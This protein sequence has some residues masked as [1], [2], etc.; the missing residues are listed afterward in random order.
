MHLKSEDLIRIEI[1]FDSGSIPP[2]F[3]HTFR[4]KISFEKNFLN[5]Q[6]DL[7]Y[8]HREELTDEEILDEGFPLDGNY[9]YVGELHNAWEKPLKSLYLTSKWSNKKLD[10]DEGGVRVLAKDLHGKITRTVPLNQEEWQYLAQEIIQAIYET[11]KKEAPLIIN[12]LKIDNDKTLEISL[13]MKFSIR[14]ALATIDGQEKEL[15]WEKTKELL[16]Y[17]FLP[18][19]DYDKAREGKPSKRGIYIDCGDGFW[20]EFGKGIYN[21]DSSYDA[22][23]KIREGFLKL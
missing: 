21:I 4:L 3:S 22:V 5:T 18:D 19:Y 6:L 9:N 11:S 17:V 8:T 23:S 1:D 14:K 12:F 13:T 20:H 7:E 2:P 16:S 15:N 10:E